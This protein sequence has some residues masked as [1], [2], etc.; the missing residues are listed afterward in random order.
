M[1]A[2]TEGIEP[3]PNRDSATS[4]VP[5]V[6]TANNSAEAAA[7]STTEDNTASPHLGEMHLAAPTLGTAAEAA[8]VIHSTGSTTGLEE[9]VSLVPYDANLSSQ[10][11]DDNASAA[12]V[13]HGAVAGVSPPVLTSATQIQVTSSPHA[14]T[15]IVNPVEAAVNSGM[16]EIDMSSLHPETFGVDVASPGPAADSAMSDLGREV[17]AAPVT[18]DAGPL[19]LIVTNAFDSE[20]HNTELE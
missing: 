13:P 11:P 1:E 17:D 8:S 7:A 15:T 6:V 9:S 2:D 10:S 16:M 18:H 5:M 4:V 19:P 20:E 14:M 3:G 12:G